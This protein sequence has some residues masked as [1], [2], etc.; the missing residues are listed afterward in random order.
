M[1][2]SEEELVL[3]EETVFDAESEI[4]VETVFED[5]P[6][7]DSISEFPSPQLARAMAEKTS[8]VQNMFFF[9]LKYL[10]KMYFISM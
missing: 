1:T 9:I 7:I 3:L 10:S 2:C 5:N 8:K 6:E 4:E